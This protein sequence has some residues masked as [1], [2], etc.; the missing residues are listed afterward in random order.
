MAV[1]N[2]F[3][4]AAEATGIDELWSLPS[5]SFNVLRS[6][7]LFDRRRLMAANDGHRSHRQDTVV[8]YASAPISAT[9]SDMSP[10]V[11]PEINKI[12]EVGSWEQT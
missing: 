2:L 6:S 3:C 9:L 11:W 4:S 12:C 7:E 8:Q 5:A 10:Q 1:C